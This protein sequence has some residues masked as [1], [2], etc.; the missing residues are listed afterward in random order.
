MDKTKVLL[1]LNALQSKV[2]QLQS[3]LCEVQD[4]LQSIE[5]DLLEVNE[6]DVDESFWDL[7]NKINK[8]IKQK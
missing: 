1:K 2:Q 3:K 8:A 7:I 5:M 4:Q 6:S